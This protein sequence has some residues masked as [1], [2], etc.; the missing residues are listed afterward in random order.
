L[1]NL[2]RAEAEKRLAKLV[3]RGVRLSVEWRDFPVKVARY[4]RF[5]GRVFYQSLPPGAP[6]VAPEATRPAAGE[7]GQKLILHVLRY[8]PPTVPS[9]VGMDRLGVI[10]TLARLRREGVRVNPNWVE[11]PVA[12]SAEHGRVLSQEPKV[13]TPLPQGDW[14]LTLRLGRW[15]PELAGGPGSPRVAPAGREGAERKPGAPAPAVPAGTRAEPK[16]PQGEGA[17]VAETP[18]APPALPPG[19]ASEKAGAI[20][21]VVPVL[22]NFVGMTSQKAYR[23]ARELFR[24]GAPI[25]VRWDVAA[26]SDRAKVGQVLRQS[27]PAGR[28]L[29]EP[30]RVV[31]QVANRYAPSPSPAPPSTPSA[32]PAAPAGKKE[33]AAVP[34]ERAMPNLLGLAPR[35]AKRILAGWRE[36]G[37]QFT[38]RWTVRPVEEPDQDLRIVDQSIAAGA[39][40]PSDSPQVLLTVGRY[41]P[42]AT[43]P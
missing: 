4:R 33:A 20:G 23:L 30:P 14:E 27:V 41:R 36:K 10:R 38:V 29:S 26:T 7:S 1:L 31:L 13:G 22:P 15:T 5:D 25:E 21:G 2:E 12:R 24:Q 18:G 43:R 16:R 37:V 11:A 3:R 28:G 39:A 19:T 17:A 42:R 34:P 8:R 32:G 9:L 40:I 35:E 6:L